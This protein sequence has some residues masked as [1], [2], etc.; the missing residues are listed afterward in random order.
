MAKNE[1]AFRRPFAGVFCSSQSRSSP[2]APSDTFPVPTPPSGNA[3]R[4][5]VE[6]MDV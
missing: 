1:Y 5:K 3:A 4:V 2:R 6:G